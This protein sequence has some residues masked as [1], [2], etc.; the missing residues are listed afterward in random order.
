[1]AS[2]SQN[3]ANAVGAVP[4][5]AVPAAPA[6]AAAVFDEI[7]KADAPPLHP[8][9]RYLQVEQEYSQAR[10]HLA[11]KAENAPNLVWREMVCKWGYDVVD[12]MGEDRNIVYAAMNILD[13]FCAVASPVLMSEQRYEC[14][15]MTALFVAAGVTMRGTSTGNL[16]MMDLINMSRGSVT[17]QDIIDMG[18]EMMRVLTW[19]RRFLTPCDFLRAMLSSLPSSVTKEQKRTLFESASFLVEISVCD[20][21]LSRIPA[22]QVA[23]C[24]MLNASRTEEIMSKFE[25][26]EF[27]RAIQDLSSLSLDAT[28][29]KTRTVRARLESV[30]RSIDENPEGEDDSNGGNSYSTLHYISD[31][32]E[33]EEE[34]DAPSLSKRQPAVKSTLSYQSHLSSL[35]TSPSK[36][37]LA[38]CARASSSILETCSGADASMR[39]VCVRSAVNFPEQERPLKRPR[40]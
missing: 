20:I 10:D 38:A 35:V 17:L 11:M 28:S 23:F 36:T 19:G 8:L 7:K 13:R 22:S 32:E 33:N 25:T 37:V 31:N 39:Q 12:M 9:Q 27:C 1:M 24:A 18:R 14:A 4:V 6:A 26:D 3:R 5:P 15:S 21:Y 40:C 29:L 2:T 30:Y 34:D 16:Q